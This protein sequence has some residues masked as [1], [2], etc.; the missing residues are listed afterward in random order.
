VAKTVTMSV[1]QRLDKLANLRQKIV[2]ADKVRVDSIKMACPAAV[3]AKIKEIEDKFQKEKLELEERIKAV[4][5]RIRSE[6][7]AQGKTAK[8]EYLMA[9]YVSPSV[10]YDK[11]KL[12]IL[13]K[14]YPVIL[15]A[16][17][18]ADKGTCTIRR[19]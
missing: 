17:T 19:I 18:V 11:N 12:E 15:D 10:S 2:L 5:E 14:V 8:G 1:E 6:V 9:V 3:R 4:E 13:E 7:V 16:K